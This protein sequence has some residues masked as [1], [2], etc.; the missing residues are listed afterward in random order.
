MKKH[1]WSHVSFSVIS[2]GNGGKN[3]GC[4]S[5]FLKDKKLFKSCLK[6]S[7]EAIRTVR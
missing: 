3:A 6:K 1:P 2:S 4:G 5:S 7:Q